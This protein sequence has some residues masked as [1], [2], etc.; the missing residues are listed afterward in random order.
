MGVAEGTWGGALK[1]AQDQGAQSDKSLFN[2]VKGPFES[3][4]RVHCAQELKIS[5]SVFLRKGVEG[6]RSQGQRPRGLAVR[7]CK[8]EEEMRLLA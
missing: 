8:Q 7:L 1:P 4:Q 2:E 3:S 5:P 6:K